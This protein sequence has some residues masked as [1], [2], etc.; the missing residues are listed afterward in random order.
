MDLLRG[1]CNEVLIVRKDVTVLTKG[2]E[3]PCYDPHHNVMIEECQVVP[4]KLAAKKSTDHIGESYI[5]FSILETDL[6]VMA[7]NFELKYGEGNESR[8]GW[9][10]LSLNEQ[11]TICPMEEEQASTEKILSSLDIPFT[12]A[13]P[14]DKDPNYV[15]YNS[16]LLVSSFHLARGKLL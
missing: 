2:E 3:E 7:S 12:D 4:E 10:I 14:W 13:I 9:K 16:T 15:D 8:I 6:Q 1:D 11:I 5:A